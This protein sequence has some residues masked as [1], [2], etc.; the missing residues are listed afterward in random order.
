MEPVSAPHRYQVICPL[1][2]GDQ[3]HPPIGGGCAQQV[4]QLALRIQRVITNAQPFA[5]LADDPVEEMIG[6]VARGPQSRSKG[7]ATQRP[8]TEEDDSNVHMHKPTDTPEKLD[9]DNIVRIVHG[10]YVVLSQSRP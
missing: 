3:L 8:L 7:I 4:N 9:Y 2:A 6:R 5:Q 10:L 1:L